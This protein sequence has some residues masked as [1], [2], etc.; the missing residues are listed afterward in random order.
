MAIITLT[1]DYGNKDYFTA[2][3]KGA[4]LSEAPEVQI[5]DISHQISPFNVQEGAY[6]LKNAYHHFPGG[7]IHMIGI[8]AE[9]TKTKQH[10]ACKVNG[11]FFIGPDT[12]IF[13]LMFPNL[14]A[15]QIIALNITQESDSIPF[16]MK[17]VFVKAACH[18]NRGGTLGVIGRQINQ[19]KEVK[20]FQP[21]L[22]ADRKILNGQVI[23]IDHYGNVISNITEK[24][25]KESFAGTTYEIRLPRRNKITNL[26][27]SYSQVPEGEMIALFNSA[28][29]LEIAINKG[30]ANLANGA[31]GLLG[32]KV[33]DRISIEFL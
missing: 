25:F 4:I 10:I 15:E 7:T 33:K 2:A 3:I 30:D 27:K 19:L 32:I 12:G 31:S 18:L 22:S 16:P 1:T 11:H 9:A 5:I 24:F 20:D 23:Y 29:H 14:K 17:D 8:D 26:H 13:S 28:G 21:T 6:I